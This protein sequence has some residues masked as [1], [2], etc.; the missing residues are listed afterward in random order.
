MQTAVAR[1]I[2]TWIIFELRLVLRQYKRDFVRVVLRKQQQKIVFAQ[3]NKQFGKCLRLCGVQNYYNFAVRDA[4]YV[5]F[6]CASARADR[7]SAIIMELTR[8]LR[9]VS[10]A[11]RANTLCISS[12]TVATTDKNTSTNKPKLAR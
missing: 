3:R 4:H 2:T 10:A 8:S 12:K 11:A 6:V 9:I 5:Y 7:M 1:S